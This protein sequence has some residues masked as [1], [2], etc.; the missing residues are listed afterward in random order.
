MQSLA[1]LKSKSR[2][3]YVNALATF[4][5]IFMCSAIVLGN[6]HFLYFLVFTQQ[7]IPKFFSRFG[8]KI[9]DSFRDLYCNF[10]ISNFNLFMNLLLI[11]VM[12]CFAMS[13]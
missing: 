6:T 5:L 8:E 2:H 10:S 13:E 4:N 3:I 11:T 12:N 7:T 1:G 9:Q